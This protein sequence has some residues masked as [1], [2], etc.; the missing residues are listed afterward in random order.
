MSFKLQQGNTDYRPTPYVAQWWKLQQCH[1]SYRY[2][3]QYVGKTQNP[4]HIHLNGHHFD[5]KNNKTEKSVAAHFN[6]PGHSLSD[7][8]ILVIEK[9]RTL[10]PTVN[11]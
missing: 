4:L 5:I 3:K 10:D 6:I 7:L 1:L 8:T 9:V 11:S 2:K